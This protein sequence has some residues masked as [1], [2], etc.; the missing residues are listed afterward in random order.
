MINL[1]SLKKLYTN[2]PLWMKLLYS[3]IPYDVRSGSEY[4][5]WKQ[6]LEK[7]INEEEY[8]ILKLKETIFYAYENTVYYKKLFDSLDCSVYDINDLKDIQKLPLIDKDMVRENYDDL[9]AK[10]YPRNKT[11]YVT[12]GGSSGD[13]MKF[14]QSK[15][16]WAK[17]LAFVNQYFLSLGYDSSYLKASFRGGEFSNL[18]E[19]VFWKYNPIQNEIHFSPFHIN[20]KTI[21]NYVNHLNNLQPLFLHSYPSAILALIENMKD[22]NLSLDY[23]LKTIFLISENIS[24]DELEY[25]SDFFKCKVSAFFGHSERLIFASLDI[26]TNK[27]YIIHKK[28]GLTELIDTNTNI[29]NQENQVG[30][31]IGTS[32]DNLAMP[33]IRYRTNDFT[34]YNHFNNKLNLIEGRWNKEYLEGKDGLKLTLTAL[35]MHS[36]IFKNVIYFQFLQNEVSKVIILIVPK[37][38]YTQNDELII[39]NA[40]KEKGGHAVE[41]RINIVEM[42]ILTNR[43]KMKKLIKEL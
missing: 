4:R 16:I 8:Q 11:F 40:M 23:Q 19:N 1:N 31:L 14:L 18:N 41:F 38:T 6:F 9:I 10:N 13:P 42:P 29:I 27:N 26:Q 20:K 30:E 12:T 24:K 2:S 22:V 39:L 28:Y 5:K 35:N 3:S 25:I 33:L 7:E 17:E 21:F 15:N 32:F 34:S 36:D 43:G 37:A